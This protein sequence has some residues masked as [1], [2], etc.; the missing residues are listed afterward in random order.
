MSGLSRSVSRHRGFLQ[1]FETTNLSFCAST[2]QKTEVAGPGPVSKV[3]KINTM[4]EVNGES[5]QVSRRRF[6]R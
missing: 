6:V 1:L 2:F 3:N 4:N 5:I